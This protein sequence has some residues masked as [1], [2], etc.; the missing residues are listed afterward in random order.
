MERVTHLIRLKMLLTWR[1]YTRHTLASL[2]SL[3]F[4]LVYIT[5][6]VLSWMVFG[7]MAD[8]GTEYFVPRPLIYCDLFTFLFVIWL[9]FSL[10]GYRLNESYDL[11]RLL[12]FP[13]PLRSVFWAN[14]I[15]SFTDISV[16][17]PLV[18][19]LAV[20]F[21]TGPSPGQVP[22][23]VALILLLLLLQVVA[24]LTLVNVLY[25]MLPR[26]NLVKVGMWA[27]LGVLVWEGLLKVGVIQYP[28]PNFYALFR[29]F[30]LAYFR[31]Y[32]AGQISIALGAYLDGEYADMTVP[33]LG[34]AG[35]IAGILVL[36]YLVLAYWM[37]LDIAK[38]TPSEQASRND[39]VPKFFDR[40]GSFMEPLV[41]RQAYSLYRKDTLEFAIRSPYFFIYKI[42]PGSVA[43]A[44][45][46]LAMRFNMSY[47][48]DMSSY[49][50]L[51]EYALPGAMVLVLFIVIAQANLFA[52]NQFGL[53]DLMIR[54]LMVLPAPRKAYLLG[55]NLFLGGLFLVDAIVLSLLSLLFYDSAYIFFAVFTLLVTLFLLVLSI[56]NFTSSI[57]PY[58]MPFDKPSFTLRSTVI[59]GLVNTGVSIVLAVAIFPALAAVALPY[60]Y[61]VEG[62][63]YFLMPLSILYGFL[64]HRLTLNPAVGVM[65][66]NEFLIIRRVADRE[67]L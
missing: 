37:E 13:L 29:E 48:E 18:S 4:V 6:L 63:G 21:A 7:K 17:L 45:I 65:E 15:G 44:I 53:E 32:P 24:G 16:L 46:L 33:L 62:L 42:L 28:M 23:G 66:N 35:W 56:G 27:A 64:F 58:W 54:E 1:M 39:P 41:G 3:L 59:L 5:W 57:W 61:H 51:V 26:L 9:I 14:I 2:E 12:L 25:I 22:I 36:N 8:W 49:P 67:Q 47:I 38:R 11:N 55:K 50:P 60:F 43:P 20:F 52:G 40:A 19:Y 30:G 31:P 34:F 10:L